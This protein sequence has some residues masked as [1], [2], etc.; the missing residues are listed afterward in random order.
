[1]SSRQF[2][3]LA[4]FLFVALAWA[5]SLW[6][7]LSAVLLGLIGYAVGRVLDGDVELGQLGELGR[8]AD[9]VTSARNQSRG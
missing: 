2:G 5:A 9:R 3:Y 1:M 7:A 6:V 4:G 8:F